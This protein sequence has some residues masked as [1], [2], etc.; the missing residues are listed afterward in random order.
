MNRERIWL[1]LFFMVVL[2]YIL[3]YAPFGFNS[4]D[5][6]F[7]TG[8]AWQLMSGKTLY[9]EVLYVRPPVSVWLRWLEMQFVPGEWAILSERW[10]F[11]LKVAL[12]SYAGAAVWAKGLARNQLALLAFILS[13]H[14]YPATGWHTVDGLLFGSLGVYFLLRNTT[15]SVLTGG[16]FLALAMLTKQ[17]FYPLFVLPFL[18][19][20]ILSWRKIAFAYSGLLLG[21][22]ST[23]WILI[24]QGSFHSFLDLVTASAGAGEALQHG[25][26]D[27]FSINPLLLAGGLI[28][29]VLPFR[30]IFLSKQSHLSWSL[31]SGV[32]LL[33]FLVDSYVLTVYSRQEFTLPFAQ[34]RFL[35][36]LGILYLVWN[37]IQTE[38]NW[39]RASK[40]AVL[41]ALSWC[42]AISW[43]YNLPILFGLPLIIPLWEFGKTLIQKTGAHRIGEW[44]PPIMAG[45]LISAFCFAYQFI[46]RDGDR[47]EM[48]EHL[49]SVYPGLEGIY[50]DR[51]TKDKLSELKEFR[52][53]HPK[54]VVLPYGTQMDFLE[55][56]TPVFPLD[57][58]ANREMGGKEDLVLYA[59]EKHR[60]ALLIEKEF[61]DKIED[62]S[63]LSIIKMMMDQ[64]EIWQTG[65]YFILFVPKQHN[66]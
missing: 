44:M 47:S 22:A 34:T 26:F 37:L 32:L 52:S 9:S 36:A 38:I 35:F 1:G 6:G 49:V 51:E 18:L 61:L 14:C 54:S 60:P 23:I 33:L 31:I 3:I 10:L 55:R 62:D 63:E 21:T 4:S 5:G 30:S 28:L 50:S 40:Y 29:L 66:G 41:L 39:I 7:L 8:L 43:G 25:V 57:W 56:T 16:L 53:L 17:S 46:Y 42:G 19:C 45:L 27:Y 64:C 48:K 13:A 11:Y 2:L 58:V 59:F 65:D 20:P 24:N 12:Y 15:A